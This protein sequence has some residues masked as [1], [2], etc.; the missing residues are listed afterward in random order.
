MERRKEEKILWID[1]QYMESGGTTNNFYYNIGNI[2]Y[3]NNN[4]KLSVQ[5]IECIISK[6]FINIGGT[7]LTVYSPIPFYTTI[8]KIYINFKHNNTLEGAF[9]MIS[10]KFKNWNVSP[11]PVL[12]YPI[13]FIFIIP[14]GISFKSYFILLSFNLQLPKLE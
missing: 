12:L 14:F 13:I 3:V 7:G 4:K 1:S 9:P 11:V 5:L 10:T 2:L 6:N 8:I